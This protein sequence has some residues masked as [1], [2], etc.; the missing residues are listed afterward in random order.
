MLAL[1]LIVMG[2]ILGVLVSSFFVEEES[3]WLTYYIGGIVGLL[4]SSVILEIRNVQRR[5]KELEEEK[6]IKKIEF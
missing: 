2:T 4:V 5:K 6:K 1:L 3:T